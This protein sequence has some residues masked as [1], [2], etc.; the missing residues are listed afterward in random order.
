LAGGHVVDVAVTDGRVAAVI[1]QVPS[2][3]NRAVVFRIVKDEGI[4]MLVKLVWFRMVDIVRSIFGMSAKVI[5][6]GAAPGHVG[7]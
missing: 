4:G 2:M 3:D 5:P 1:A 7:S 6:A